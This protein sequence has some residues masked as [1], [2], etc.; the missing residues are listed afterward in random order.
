MRLSYTSQF[1]IKCFR[2]HGIGF[3]YLNIFKTAYEN[4][5]QF[6][7]LSL[8]QVI[9]IQGRTHQVSVVSVYVWQDI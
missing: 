3:Q 6:N 9:K 2:S 1:K 7:Y 5:I 8:L 4:L